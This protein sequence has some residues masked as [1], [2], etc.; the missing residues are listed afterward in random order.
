[1]PYCSWALKAQRLLILAN[2][3]GEIRRNTVQRS[4]PYLGK[5]H[6][7][8]R[9]GRVAQCV[10]PKF[11]PQYCKKKTKK[12]TLLTPDLTVESKSSDL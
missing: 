4:S 11:E 3:E 12:D 1:M 7:K 8:E 2:Q 10:G 5:N 6:H 9:P